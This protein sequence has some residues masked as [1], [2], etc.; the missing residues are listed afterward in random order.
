MGSTH[1]A[2]Q[3]FVK[4]TISGGTSENWLE[5]IDTGSADAVNDSG[6][7][8]KREISKRGLSVRDF[9]NRWHTARF[10]DQC[11][12]VYLFYGLTQ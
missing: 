11:N 5:L 12:S 9:S 8:C 3:N 10:K 4:Q 6:N 1:A 2:Q 7:N